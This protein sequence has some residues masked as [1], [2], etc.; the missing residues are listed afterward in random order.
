MAAA[1]PVVV[2][3]EQLLGHLTRA[4]GL[5]FTFASGRSDALAAAMAAALRA[6]PAEV[7]QFEAA[8]RRYAA[9]YSRAA[10]TAQLLRSLGVA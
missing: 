3:D 2:S 9:R 6:G 4:H 5:G 7:A 1:R 8:A 10:F